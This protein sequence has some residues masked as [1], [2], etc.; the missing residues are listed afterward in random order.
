MRYIKRAT[1]KILLATILLASLVAGS[2]LIYATLVKAEDPS[3][4]HLTIYQT[5]LMT[6]QGA[7]PR[8][9]FTNT[10]GK[11]VDVVG[12][13]DVFGQGAVPA[14]TYKRIRF[15]VKNLVDYAGPDP[16]THSGTI[17]RTLKIDAGQP[18]TAQ[19]T[20]FFAT[21]DD[22]GSSDWRANGTETNPFLIQNPIVVEANATIIVRLIFNTAGTLVCTNNQPEVMG[23]TMNALYYIDQA[24]ATG[25][26]CSS[27]G[28]YWFF[29]YR[30]S[31]FPTD[32][33]GS[34]IQN[35]TLAQIMASGNVESGWGTLTFSAPNPS[36]GAGSWTLDPTKTYA[37]GGMAAHRHSLY[38]NSG[39]GWGYFDPEGGT[40]I[41]AS[42][43]LK[44][45]TM[46]MTFPGQFTID[47]ALSTDCSTFVGVNLAAREGSDLI[48]ALKKAASQPSFAI[49]AKYVSVGPQVNI[50]YDAVTDITAF[51]GYDSGW[52]AISFGATL[53]DGMFVE[54]K[55]RFDMSPNFSGSGSWTIQPA[56]EEADMMMAV[57]A[58]QIRSDGLVTQMS[59]TNP[60]DFIAIGA[61][62]N[63]L[64]AGEL[65]DL[66]V[67]FPGTH[68]MAAGFFARAFPSPTLSDIAG[69]WSI[70]ILE[71]RLT[72][73]N[74]WGTGISYGNI[75]VT[76][77]GSGN[78]RGCGGFTY[79]DNFSSTIEPPDTGCSAIELHTECYYYD[80]V[81]DTGQPVT[82]APASCQGFTMP[83]F[84]V[85]GSGGSVEAKFVL[86][87]NR[88]TIVIWSPFDA[89]GTP[90]ASNTTCTADPLDRTSAGVGVK[91][92]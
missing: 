86:D 39:A 4:V 22:G 8:T 51:M 52:S 19:V 42:Y 55:N 45:N 31:S 84:Y 54:W 66:S 46:L 70:G 92:K 79:R 38:D 56:I 68:R 82:T 25:T 18:D 24:P 16:C 21:S 20:L 89:N 48:V 2:L 15:T 14:G 83:V 13:P 10:A 62:G 37:A 35:P 12:N 50:S 6:G 72:G 67:R 26:Y 3:G 47:G 60:E 32:S 71:T 27:L 88:S 30:I 41:S 77:D 69:T 75:T 73:S 34:L 90:C 80:P 76:V 5:D 59:G 58:F 11:T 91:T 28:D 74:S 64:A 65:T 87:N 1:T 85:I 44:G 63:G 43:L 53:N 49:N 57:P 81:T 9:I 61:N 40:V 33:T 23:P 29:H 36:T 7:T 17:S 78:A